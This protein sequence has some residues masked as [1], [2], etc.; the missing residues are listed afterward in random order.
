MYTIEIREFTQATADACQLIAQ[1]SAQVPELDKPQTQ[2]DI[3]ERLAANPCL[4]LVAYVEGEVAGFKLG[5]AK[6]NDEFYSWLG[7]VLPDFRQLGLA[8]TMLEY[9]EKW[10]AEQGYKRLSVKTRNHFNAMLN[11]LVSRQYHITGLESDHHDT[12]NNKLHL[13]KQLSGAAAL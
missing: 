11:M 10:A 8:K 7:G 6:Q 13:Q 1:L 12:S 2:L 9:Q 5:Y 3:A 4:I